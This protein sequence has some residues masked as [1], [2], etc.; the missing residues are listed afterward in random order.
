M[1]T[2]LVIGRHTRAQE[3][4][5][6]MPTQSLTNKRK[7]H[8][9]TRHVH[10]YQPRGACKVIFDM[11]DEEVLISGPAGTGKSRACLEKIF[12]V[13][14]L[15]AN[16]R[17]LILRKTLAS[18]GSSALVTWR[19][20]VIP[21]AVATG[22]VV[23]YGGSK[24]EP[25]QYRFKNGS[26]VTIGGLDKATRIMST[27]YDIVYVQEATECTLDDLEMITSRLRN[28]NIGFQQ[29]LMDCNPDS[30][31]HWLK[32]RS[33][34]GVTKL[35]ESRH[36]DNPRLFDL[37]PDGSHQVTERGAKY[38]GILDKL[39]GVRYKRLRLGLWVSAEGIVYEEFD[40]AKHILSWEYDEND[41]RL[42]LPAEWARYWVIDFGF[43][44]PFVLKCYAQGSDGE[45][46]M[47]R[48]I[49]MTG[50]TV[51]EHAE[52]I[53]SIVR[54]AKEIKW[55]NHIDRVEHTRIEYEWIEP[56]P[57]A[58]IC[59]HDAEGRRTFE[60]E[61][62]L[63][64]QPAI[65]FV[66]DGID[67]HKDRLKDG[68]D[69]LPGFY[70]MEDSL[71]ELDQSLRDALMPTCTKDEYPAYVWKVTSDGRKQDEPVKRDDHGMDT[72]RYMTMYLDYKGKVR[73]TEID[74]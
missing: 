49:Y 24:E 13:C 17:A 36:E 11:R 37:L 62:G 72:D 16:T 15:T 12:M 4:K 33:N 6:Q 14:M 40:P 7:Q 68:P 18:L 34:D 8:T 44:H 74:A 69:D 43:V 39:T 55:Y 73:Y 25:A 65:K 47:Y 66:N 54:P 71:V 57:T 60:K 22:H 23:Y 59:D 19:K 20:F 1:P 10:Q 51:A 27:E 21:E 61:T 35:I 32:L 52:Q 26:S 28:W 38:I 29:L 58:V 48:E 67:L 50:R 41:N 70:L 2:L 3:R 31:K 56:K 53:M 42:P 46:Y 64:T 63:G 9:G 30:D 45:I 5:R